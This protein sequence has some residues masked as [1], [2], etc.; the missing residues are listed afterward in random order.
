MNETK[1][2][3]YLAPRITGLIIAVVTAFVIL[4]VYVLI[5]LGINRHDPELWAALS[6]NSPDAVMTTPSVLIM[7]A[8]ITTSIGAGVLAS[9]LLTTIA[10]HILQCDIMQPDASYPTK[11]YL[12]H[13]AYT[14]EDRIQRAQLNRHKYR[15][16]Y[17][18]LIEFEAKEMAEIMGNMKQLGNLYYELPKSF[19][20]PDNVSWLQ[21]RISLHTACTIIRSVPSHGTVILTYKVAFPTRSQIERTEAVVCIKANLNSPTYTS[22]GVFFGSHNRGF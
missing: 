12:S 6:D 11:Y 13:H 3:R 10:N 20:M 16:A 8:H 7:M 17:T 1:Q 15:K 19:L 2:I 14:D 22:T 5:A 18:V 21:P 4:A 9:V